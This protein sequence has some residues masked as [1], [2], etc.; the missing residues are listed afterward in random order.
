[1]TKGSL[2]EFPCDFPIKIVGINS[3]DFFDAIKEI[4]YTHFP[5][6]DDTRFAHTLSGKNNYMAIT[7]TVVA[8]SQP[9]LDA[10]YQAL[11][12]HPHVKMVL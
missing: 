10:L 3:D 6:C 1:M 7:V 8:T 11:T 4:V 2:I 5:D 12:N 9:M